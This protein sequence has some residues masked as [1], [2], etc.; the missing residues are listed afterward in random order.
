MSSQVSIQFARDNFANLVAQTAIAGQQ[1]VITKFGKPSAMLV[2]VTT[3][4]VSKRNAVLQAT[5]GLWKNRTDIKDT[6]KWV[7]K[8]RRKMSLRQRT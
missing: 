6:N 5:S 2:P 4:D 1:F 3:D 7:A 8:L